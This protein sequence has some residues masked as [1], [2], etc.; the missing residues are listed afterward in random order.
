MSTK[1]EALDAA[2]AAVFEAGR[3]RKSI[4]G[5]WLD[6][7]N[8][9]GPDL[10]ARAIEWPSSGDPLAGLRL[11]QLAQADHEARKAAIAAGASIPA[12]PFLDE[13]TRR[14]S[15]MT[16]TRAART[17][18]TGR[19]SRAAKTAELRFVHDG[20]LVAPTQHKLS[21]VA[22]WYTQGLGE[23][24]GRM[25]A[26]QLRSLL[27][28]NGVDPDSA[29]WS[30]TLANGIT[31]GTLEKGAAEPS[32]E[33]KARKPRA[34]KAE[35]AAKVPAKRKAPTSA[36]KKKRTAA[37]VDAVVESAKSGPNAEATKAA[38]AKARSSATAAPTKLA[39]DNRRRK[40]PV[41][42]A[43]AKKVTA[44]RS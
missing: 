17:E 18:S 36:E 42:K 9:F 43:P 3:D 13:L 14:H 38:N 12:L 2:I 32:S 29:G 26:K 34:P 16:T 40:P 1:A 31:I 37:I 27:E 6:A 19:A 15:N 11:T 22:Y 4:A 30:Y 20:K 44:T 21:S 39:P 25:T 35:P 41:K 28:E 33:P 5:K 23:E 24:G 8:A 7:L 10:A